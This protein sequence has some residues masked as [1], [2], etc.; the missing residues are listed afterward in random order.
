MF[1]VFSVFITVFSI[2]FTVLFN[3]L[4][5][6]HDPAMLSTIAELQV[7]VI[8][9]HMRGTPQTMSNKEFTEYKTGDCI[10][11]IATGMYCSNSNNNKNIELCA[12]LCTAFT[13]SYKFYLIY[14]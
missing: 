14:L 6:R 3:Y 9:M 13:A 11:E 8:M 10:A 12:M 5:G 1:T 4:G 2:F 7:P